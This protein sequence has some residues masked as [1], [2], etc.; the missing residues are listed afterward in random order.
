MKNVLIKSKLI[1]VLLLSTYGVATTASAK[2]EKSFS[3]DKRN[4]EDGEVFFI[5]KN[6][7]KFYSQVSYYE[8]TNL[9]YLDDKNFFVESNFSTNETVRI[10]SFF[11]IEKGK[12]VLKKI[13]SFSTLNMLAPAGGEEYC[14]KIINLEFTKGVNEYVDQYLFNEAEKGNYCKV[15]KY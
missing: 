10:K 14:K 13:T 6:K 9:H 2:Q 3:L 1:L 4:N 8:D 11:K 15:R 5:L 7:Q 12:L